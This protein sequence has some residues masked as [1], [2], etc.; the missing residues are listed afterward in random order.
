[1]LFKEIITVYSENHMKPLCEQ[2]KVTECYCRWYIQLPLGSEWLTA[3][4]SIIT[5]I[6]LLCCNNC[7]P[8]TCTEIL[9]GG[10]GVASC[11]WQ[12]MSL[13]HRQPSHGEAHCPVSSSCCR[14][15][16][17]PV[18]LGFD[19][20]WAQDPVCP[21]PRCCSRYAVEACSRQSL[22]LMWQNWAPVQ[23]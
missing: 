7:I 17:P 11:S 10:T 8:A 16:P 18:P 13:E 4:G 9:A 23:Q 19:A 2:N 14:H 20:W 21:Q 3:N 22:Q 6:K 15:P 5:Y 12:W 1:M